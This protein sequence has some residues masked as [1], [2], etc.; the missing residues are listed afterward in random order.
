MSNTESFISFGLLA[1]IAFVF[2]VY[3]AF[4]FITHMMIGTAV[5]LILPSAQTSP[6]SSLTVT[7]DPNCNDCFVALAQY[8][9][10]P[11]LGYR[12]LVQPYSPQDTNQTEEQY[13]YF[14]TGGVSL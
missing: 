3:V 11:A 5:N 2:G 10:Q 7:N 6:T 1:G 13:N 9:V 14:Q 12:A 8:D 4:I